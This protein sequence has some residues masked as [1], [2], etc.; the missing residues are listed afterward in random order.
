MSEPINYYGGNGKELPNKSDPFLPI[1]WHDYPVVARGKQ[2]LVGSDFSSFMYDFNMSFEGTLW[3]KK[4][5]IVENLTDL[6][7]DYV[8]ARSFSAADYNRDDSGNH[9]FDYVCVATNEGGKKSAH[10]E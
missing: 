3:T 7:G 1:A 2:L 9:Q 6:K 10:C 8:A 4:G 5:V